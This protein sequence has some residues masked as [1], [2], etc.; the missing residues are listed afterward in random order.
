M[1]PGNALSSRCQSNLFA[2]CVAIYH[3]SS[4]IQRVRHLCSA[5]SLVIEINTL[6]ANEDWAARPKTVSQ[7]DEIVG[8]EFRHV[9]RDTMLD[10]S[11]E[12]DCTS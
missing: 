12:K 9:S 3:T 8:K 5:V 6:T 2:K 11:V 7:R 1:R 4:R 10:R